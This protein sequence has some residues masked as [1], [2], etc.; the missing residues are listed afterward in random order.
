MCD[1]GVTDAT[2]F[3]HCALCT[4]QS[5]VDCKIEKYSNENNGE[6]LKD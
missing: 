6:L 2:F 5:W 4:E 3:V 1:D